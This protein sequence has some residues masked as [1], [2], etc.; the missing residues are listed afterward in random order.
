MKVFHEDLL[1]KC[2]HQSKKKK[3]CLCYQYIICVVQHVTIYYQ[4]Q[5]MVP[6]RTVMTV[7][8]IEY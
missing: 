5:K 7:E 3:Y 4:Q 6:Y 2:L 1:L 8:S